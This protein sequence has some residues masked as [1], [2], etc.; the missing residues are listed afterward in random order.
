MER[1]IDMTWF[2]PAKCAPYYNQQV[3]IKTKVDEI[4]LAYYKPCAYGKPWH[5][6]EYTHQEPHSALSFSD[7]YIYRW[8]P[9]SS[10]NAPELTKEL[11]EENEA[12]FQKSLEEFSKLFSISLKQTEETILK[13]LGK[14][15]V[16]DNPVGTTLRV[17]RISAKERHRNKLRMKR[18][19]SSIRHG[20]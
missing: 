20:K 4:H 2:D 1:D 5:L 16:K 14:D 19:L 7:E 6:F 18:K 8:L 15:S 13:S 9:L 10:I 3:I 17:R 11:K 12:H